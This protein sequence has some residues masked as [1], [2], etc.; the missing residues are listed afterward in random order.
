VAERL[1]EAGYS[2]AIHYA[3][4]REAALETAEAC[5]RRAASSAQKFP[6]V[7]WDIGSAAGREALFSATMEALGHVDA[8]VNNAGIAP[9]ERADITEARRRFLTR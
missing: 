5:S 7:Q 2:V 6:I 1:A 3:S 4:N 8:L 9:R